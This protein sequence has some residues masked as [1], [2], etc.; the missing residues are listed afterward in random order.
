MPYYPKEYAPR[1]V[2]QLNSFTEIKMIHDKS[3]A[4]NQQKHDQIFSGQLSD[5]KNKE[6]KNNTTNSSEKVTKKTLKTKK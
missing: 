3:G 5:S 1:E 6:T 2:T 4:L